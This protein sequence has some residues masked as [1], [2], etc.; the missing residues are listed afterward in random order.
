MTLLT[1]TIVIYATRLVISF[2]V[3]IFPLPTRD[4]PKNKYPGQGQAAEAFDLMMGGKAQFR[5]VHTTVH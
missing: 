3:K 1:N 5:A 4:D 2:K